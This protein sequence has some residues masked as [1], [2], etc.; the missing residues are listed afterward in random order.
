MADTPKDKKENAANTLS[1]MVKAAGAVAGIG[2]LVGAAF[3]IQAYFLTKAEYLRFKCINDIEIEDVRNDTLIL[4]QSK[5]KERYIIQRNVLE[6]KPNR[7]PSED[8]ELETLNDTIGITK[9]IINDAISSEE[10]RI[11]DRAKMLRQGELI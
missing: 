11:K 5:D 2:T 10:Q 1:L 7:T 9:T 6:K 4:K 8:L 3:T